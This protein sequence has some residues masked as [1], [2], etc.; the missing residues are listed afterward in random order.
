MS[1]TKLTSSSSS[2][3]LQGRFLPGSIIA[4]RYRVIALLGKGGMGE[5][6][7][8]D[9]LTLEQAVALKLLP[10]E[11][12]ADEVQ[13]ERFRNEVRISRRVSHPN[14]CRVYDVGEVDGQTFFTMEYIDG[15][16][17][18]SLLRR[19]GRLPQDKALEISRQLCAGLAAAHAKGVL[20]RD[21]KPANI[22][23][24]GRGQVVIT[25]FGLAGLAEQMRGADIRSGT[26]AYM[27]P[28]QLEGKEV[29]PSSDIYALGLVLYE[30]FTGKRAFEADTLQELLRARTS[31]KVNRPTSVV[32]DLDPTV[33]R[34]I[35]RC[36]EAE[37]A[38]R[39]ASALLVAAALPGGDPLAAALAAGETPSP[40]MIAA[41]GQTSGLNPRVA[42]L[43]LVGALLGLV[44]VVYMSIRTSAIEMLALQQP[45]L[46]LEHTAKELIQKLG[47][48]DKPTDT[49]EG[50]FY[51]DDFLHYVQKHEGKVDW[52]KVF[53]AHPATLTFWYRQSPQYLEANE[54]RDNLL[55]PG[56]VTREDPPS[57]TSGM[58]SVHLDARG[59]LESFS[60][61]PPQKEASPANAEPVDWSLLF[62]AAGLDITKFQAAAPEWASL[63]ASD[64]RLA[65]TGSWP[66]SGRL[67]RIEAADYHGKAVFFSLLG[68]WQTPS[69]MQPVEHSATEKATQIAFLCIFFSVV[70]GALLLARRNFRKGA[71]DRNGALRLATCMFG[72]LILL[73]LT[74]SH[75][76]PTGFMVLSFVVMVSTGLF[77]SGLIWAL[78]IAL[79]P[80]I[81][82]HWPHSIISWSRL[83]MGKI[84]DPLVGRDV[85]YGVALGTL[86]IVISQV[87]TLLLIRRGVAPDFMSTAYLMGVREAASEW[88]QF[89]PNSLQG[90]L[91]FFFILLLLRILLRKPWLA[92]A[93][94]VL[95][96]ASLKTLGSPH[97]LIEAPTQ[98]LIYGI[99]L[100][101]VT[102]FGL[103]SLWV[104]I[105]TADMLGNVPFTADFSSWYAPHTIAAWCSIAALAVWG[106]YNSLGGKPLFKAELL[107]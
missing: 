25:D 19:I 56:I 48:P 68:P 32:K 79:E 30:I 77:W 42:L 64:E 9:D 43:C 107:D 14:V 91:I 66:G 1:S 78:Y 16:D 37:P 104:G 47:Y 69:R 13:L 53:A 73:W 51:D 7:R 39:P 4:G 24:D 21:L 100:L 88:L 97:P 52:P 74:R 34:V 3:T 12:S 31:S 35:L 89:P 75:F 80:Y 8:A 94:F 65:W 103:I 11:T 62:A 38:N 81:R 83:W 72:M 6:Y 54:F 60:A 40:A 84:R 49:A 95:L 76:V 67:L 58:I 23:L 57:I 92:G 105:F 71:G 96:F 45:P 90:A 46:I 44:A 36:L 28:E 15:E 86:W 99:A 70:A 41:A 106:F 61:I 63:A 82:R 33:E 29:T 55:I 98:L 87:A 50:F 93:V 101:V 2:G 17:L 59:Q 27:A 22:M 10:E 20:H 18:A 5:V 26:P 85:L 102:Q